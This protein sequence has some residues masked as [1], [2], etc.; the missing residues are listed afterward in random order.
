MKVILTLL[1]LFSSMIHSYE[2]SLDPDVLNEDDEESE[3][4]EEGEKKL[5][6]QLG[7]SGTY[8]VLDDKL[9]DSVK[10]AGTDD[11]SG[12]GIEVAVGYKGEYLT[13]SIF[14]QRFG[15][16]N[17]SIL[18][19]GVGTSYYLSDSFYVGAMAGESFLTWDT[20]PIKDTTK[21]INQ[22]GK[23]FWGFEFG[24]DYSMKNDFAL[25]TKYQFLY[26]GHKTDINDDKGIIQHK[27]QNN[28]GLGLKYGF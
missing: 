4:V 20:P 5:Y 1:L 26:L 16:S 3:Y 6:F 21:E 2:V 15:L 9:R 22:Q 12:V 10:T 18:N 24:M 13:P 28:L 17:V 14:L 25:Y 7:L 11:T 8:V 23:I 27:I 19:M